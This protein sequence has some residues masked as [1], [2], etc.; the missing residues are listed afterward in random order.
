MNAM[1]DHWLE[2]PFQ[3]EAEREA[4]DAFWESL[5]ESEEAA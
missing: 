4:E 3:E 1:Y 2:A 5:M